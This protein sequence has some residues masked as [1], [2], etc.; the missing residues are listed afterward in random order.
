MILNNKA[1]LS[2]H[3][4]KFELSISIEKNQRPRSK[5]TKEPEF[6]LK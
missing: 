6:K 4:I 3:I 1:K 5:N 2:K